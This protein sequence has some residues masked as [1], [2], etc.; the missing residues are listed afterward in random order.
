MYS[1]IE[2][3]T[4]LEREQTI[5]KTVAVACRYGRA[6]MQDALQTPLRDLIMFNQAISE[7][8]AAENKGSPDRALYDNTIEGG[9]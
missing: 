8:V 3:P 7:L 4:P 9:G 5:W 1:G 6:G 2:P